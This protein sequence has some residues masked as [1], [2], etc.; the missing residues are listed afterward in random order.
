[1]ALPA[2]IAAMRRAIAVSAAGLGATSPNPPVGCVIL[3][4]EGQVIAE[5][6]H[7][8]KGEAHAEA[9]AL[10]A[11]G[12]L[13]AGAT[14]V[15][16]L[17]PCNHQG[18]TPACRQ[19][20]I[21]AN[22]SRVVIAVLDPTSRGEGGAAALRTAGI[23]VEVGVLA[24]EARVVLGLWLAALTAR[25]PVVTW[26]YVISDQGIRALPDD[27]EDARTLRLNADA[28]LRIDGSVAEAMPG[29]HGAGILHL[30]YQLGSDPAH[31]VSSLYQ[32]GV[33]HLLLA[34][35][36]TMAAPFLAE[37]LVDHIHAYIPDGKPSRKPATSRPWPQLPPGFFITNAAKLPGFVR[38]QAQRGPV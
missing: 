28:V 37:G 13:A 23:D 18:R 10:A 35:D 25:R 27:A 12:P 31:L 20:L 22:I 1:M 14:A 19:A 33:R 6:Y 36:L 29:R 26:P 7:E 4:A 30:D 34:V 24:D 38:I 8:R 9:Q 3:D 15:V 16:T 11:A 32:G 5:G 17:E 2:E 21:D